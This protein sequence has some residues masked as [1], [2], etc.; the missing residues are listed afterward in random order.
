MAEEK[1]KKGLEGG[2][3]VTSPTDDL[4]PSGNEDWLQHKEE[5][6]F[7]KNYGD[8]FKLD[9]LETEEK[10]SEEV[11]KEFTTPAKETLKETK[12]PEIDE[13]AFDTAMSK[14]L[15]E[16]DT[17]DR[18][19]VQQ[20]KAY[21]QMRDYLASIQGPLPEI[22]LENYKKDLM[23]FY[24]DE[25]MVNAEM[26]RTEKFLNSVGQQFE[27]RM[28]QVVS[29]MM[30]PYVANNSGGGIREAFYGTY[31]DLNSP[32]LHRLVG[33]VTEQVELQYPNASLRQKFDEIAKRSREII[34]D[35]NSGLTPAPTNGKRRT[36]GS[37]SR[38][39]TRIPQQEIPKDENSQH[40][41]DLLNFVDQRGFVT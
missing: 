2:E 27:Q 28:M 5:D 39:G 26:Q 18:A 7:E 40:L 19:F 3:R 11:P 24:Q 12:E 14:Y 36:V 22:N 10:T 34:K 33:R 16:R 23:D 9:Y 32:N 17:E 41:N 30:A 6:Y 15:E 8:E 20:E 38:A 1:T 21:K 35:V 31:P 25:N 29:R 37:P 13:Q 4:M